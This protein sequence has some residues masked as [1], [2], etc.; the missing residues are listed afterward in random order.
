MKEKLYETMIKAIEENNEKE[1][2][3]LIAKRERDAAVKAYREYK[4]VEV[5]QNLTDGKR[6]EGTSIYCG[7]EDYAA[8][9]IGALGELGL[10]ADCETYTVD[11]EYMVD[12]RL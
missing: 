3:F 12:V 7:T 4:E 6:G 8:F 9:L 2:Q 11:G 10:A 5:C 1:L